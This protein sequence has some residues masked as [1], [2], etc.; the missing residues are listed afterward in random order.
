MVSFAQDNTLIQ[1]GG[2]LDLYIGTW[3]YENTETNEVFIIKL[4]KFDNYN[5]LGTEEFGSIII[6]EYSYSKNNETIHNSIND[7]QKAVSNED[8][9]N[10][11]IK[12]FGNHTDHDYTKLKVWL[13]DRSYVKMTSGYMHASIGR[14]EHTLLW[15]ISENTGDHDVFDLINDGTPAGLSIPSDIVLIKVE[16]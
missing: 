13:C 4:K 10:A 6:G 5:H 3:K 11:S 7:L 16:E 1:L 9:F 2:S 14:K 15:K 12:G 8:A